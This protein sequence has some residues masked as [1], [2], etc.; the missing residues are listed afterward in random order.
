MIEIEKKFILTDEEEKALI[1][2]A[3]FLG[4]VINTEKYY[5]D[6][7][8]SLTKKDLWFRN[9]NG[10]F[11]LKVP[12]NESIENRVSDQYMELED[13]K[14]ILEYFNVD[15]GQSMEDFLMQKGYK[16]FCEMVTTRRK[17]KKEGFNIDLDVADFG[18]KLAEIEYMIEEDVDMEEATNIVL[19]FAKKHNI[20]IPDFIYG[21]VIEYL[22]INNPKHLQILI[23]E[24]VVKE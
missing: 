2:D 16:P 8:Y 15:L 7:D 19:D 13:D 17:Y 6:A 21:K 22:K 12:M 24:K 14:D 1:K 18:Y 4:E 23:D 10:R 3:E 5:D 11:E 9:R 20:V